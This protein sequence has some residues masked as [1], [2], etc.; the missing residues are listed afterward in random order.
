MSVVIF[1]LISVFE[2]SQFSWYSPKTTVQVIYH[3][4]GTV[5]ESG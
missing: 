3:L 4:K 2:A 5:G 1:I